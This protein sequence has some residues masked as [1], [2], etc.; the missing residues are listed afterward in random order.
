LVLVAV[1]AVALVLVLARSGGSTSPVLPSSST[2]ADP[3][4][5]TLAPGGGDADA[6]TT[7]PQG[8]TRNV[9]VLVDGWSTRILEGSR[10]WVDI[11][12]VGRR[13]LNL[14]PL[15]AARLGDLRSNHPQA[16]GD[17]VARLTTAGPLA[18]CDPNACRDGM[19]AP[20]TVEQLAD[21]STLTGTGPVFEAWGIGAAVLAA[22]FPV[23]PDTGSVSFSTDL[24]GWSPA[25]L[26]VVDLDDDSQ[27][28]P[29]PVLVV[30]AG[31]GRLFPLSPAFAG[32]EPFIG[33]IDPM[34]LPATATTT[35]VPFTAGLSVAD[36]AAQGLDPRWLTYL[37]SPSTGCGVGV[38]CLPTEAGDLAKLEIKDRETRAFCV[39]DT[40]GARVEIDYLDAI[41]RVD[42]PRPTHQAGAW[43]GFTPQEVAG[44]SMLFAGTP[45][46]VSGLVEL[47]V[48]TARIAG[49][50]GGS[51]V[52]RGQVLHLGY[53]RA[54]SVARPSGE[55]FDRI[56]RAPA[57]FVSC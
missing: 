41:W 3:S 29:R 33:P 11:P 34:P 28:S 23:G 40:N 18:G 17:I 42:Y 52:L 30:A 5:P 8:E 56:L 15:D 49:A 48:T 55:I 12:Q 21:P 1:V 45:S 35:A 20:V 14:A 10:L 26:S 46:L 57:G 47:R 4:S 32:P 7:V 44:D 53:D 51:Q 2:V 19:G 50:G 24:L 37:T 25:M 27:G 9:L 22:E 43:F 13:E 39:A 31:L 36:P 6:V 16:L 38:L 54:E